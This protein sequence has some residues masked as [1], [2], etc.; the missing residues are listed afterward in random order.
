MFHYHSM[1]DDSA[2]SRGFISP[3]V[4]LLTLKVEKY[5]QNSL[6]ELEIKNLEMSE[7]L[8]FLNFSREKT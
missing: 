7:C 1:N 5:V 4:P 6:H 2:H 8:D 3:H